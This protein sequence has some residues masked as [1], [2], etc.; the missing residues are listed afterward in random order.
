M[1]ALN[2]K[3]LAILSLLVFMFLLGFSLSVQAYRISQ[4]ELNNPVSQYLR[5]NYGV[6]SIEEYQAKLE[7]EIWF[8]YSR[9]MEVLASE[10]PEFNLT[11]WQ[12]PQSYLQAGTSTYQ[13]PKITPQQPFYITMF[14]VPVTALQI[15]SLSGLGLIGLAAVPPIRK[16]KRLKQALVLGIVVLAMFSIG[17]FVGLAAAQTGA[18]TIEPGSFTE[19]ASYVIW[20]DG[21]TIYAKNGQT[22]AID[23]SGTNAASVIQSAINALTDGLIFFRNAQYNITSQLTIDDGKNIVLCGES[24]EKTVFKDDRDTDWSKTITGGSDLTSN[25]TIRNIK[26]DRSVPSSTS[27]HKYCIYDCNWNRLV[28]ENCIFIGNLIVAENE[29][30]MNLMGAVICNKLNEFIAKDNYVE[31]F[32]YGLLTDSSTGSNLYKYALIQNNIVKNSATWALGIGKASANAS[33]HICNNK[34]I[35]CAFADEGIAIDAGRTASAVYINGLINDNLIFN[36]ETKSIKNGIAVIAFN[37]VDVKNNK[38]C[39][40]GT[41]STGHPIYVF[42]GSSELAD[43][44][45]VGNTVYSYNKWAAGVTFLGVVK[46]T[47]KDNVLTCMRDSD[48]SN[49][50]YAIIIDYTVNLTY[51]SGKIQIEANTI[52]ML[53]TGYYRRG[54]LVAKTTGTGG[55]INIFI[56]KNYIY[57]A[58]RP[59]FTNVSN[60][61]TITLG[62]FNQWDNVGAGISDIGPVKTLLLE[63][64]GTATISASTSVVVTHGLAGTPT[65][66]IVTP[67]STGYGAFAVTARNSTTFTIT[68]TTSGTYTFDWYAE[69][70]P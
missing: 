54:I 15:F 45:V 21:T 20:T 55:T 60:V 48:A 53:G 51:S 24:R 61:L 44:N 27:T 30:N 16:S 58:Y 8:N 41:T 40:F 36:S 10:H 28:V 3:T 31:N 46:G 39:N 42:C 43:I 50:V 4:Q 2:Y 57:N 62:K 6:N 32:Q 37:G 66:V 52:K 68:V 69:Y 1:K 56:D 19:T 26:F 38:I 33:I 70:K 12:F 65:V 47:I 63:N 5:E 59:V 18:I 64:S 49:P 9:Q 11:R 22:G 13:P 14:S 25:V 23:Y 17:Y 35:D 34:L 7:Q 29:V 67:E